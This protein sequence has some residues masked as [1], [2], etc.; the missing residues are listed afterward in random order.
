MPRR[1]CFVFVVQILLILTFFCF[2]SLHG[3]DGDNNFRLIFTGSSTDSLNSN[4]RDV[5]AGSD[6]D[7]D[8]KFEVIVTDYDNGGQVHVFEC[9][10]N[11]TYEWVWSSPGTPSTGTFPTREV[12]TG[13]LDNDGLGEILMSVSRD[14]TPDSSYGIYVYE[15]DGI[16][17][18]GYIPIAVIPVDYQ[19]ASGFTEDFY[20]GDI[21]DDNSTELVF[22][23]AGN[24][25]DDKVYIIS[26]AGTFENEW[27]QN[28]EAVFSRSNGDF[29]TG[30]YDV[31][32]ADLDG[33]GFK[34]LIVGTIE[35]FG[36]LFIAEVTAPDTYVPQIYLHSSTIHNVYYL[37]GMA[38]ADFDNDGADELFLCMYP[39][40]KLAVL[41]S[42]ND[43]S[44][45]SRSG[46]VRILRDNVAELGVAIGDQDHGTGS[47]GLDIYVTYYGSDTEAGYI[48]DLEFTGTD[49]LLASSYTE[50]IIFEENSNVRPGGLFQIDVPTVDLDGDGKKEL[51]LSYTGET[52]NGTYLRIFEFSDPDVNC[53]RGDVNMDGN[54][55][56]GD[57]LCAFQIYLNGG[58]SPAG[59]CNTDC[60]LEA[61]DCNCTPN[62]VTPGDALY[63]FM[64]YLNNE[65]PPLDCDPILGLAKANSKYLVKL[66]QNLAK[67]T[68]E[69]VVSLTAEDPVGLKAFGL[70]IGFPDDMLEFVEMQATELTSDWECFAARE[71]LSGVVRIGGFNSEPIDSKENHII[72]RLVFRIC[73]R[74]TPLA[75]MWTFNATDNF[76]AN[77]YD[78]ITLELSAKNSRLT[79][80][81]EDYQISQNY[82]NPFN[83]ET[84]I[85][86]LLKEP[87]QVS[88]E[89]YDINGHLVRSLIQQ[90]WTTGTHRV[91]WNGKNGNGKNAGSGVYFCR[92]KAW[93]SKGEFN[94]TIKMMLL[95]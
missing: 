12:K 10:G 67:S 33:D 68:N 27:T 72:A 8:G 84:A 5:A 46:N 52:A 56:P 91:V 25:T 4:A 19:L 13:D 65:T 23:N 35:D 45:I 24:S 71:I 77:A 63:I 49:V 9:I 80:L 1:N 11:N 7:Q 54:I 64:G 26:V 82:P 34:E 40:N 18:N 61:A 32:V 21:D 86:F 47:D 87:A 75:K 94:R 89:I 30:P 42:G 74:Q 41:K 22:L 39:V 15:W 17:D 58:E 73:D 37:E 78:E 62:G 92:F 81:A 95:K 36:G 53:Q 14:D 51:L 31:V 3:A 16:N 50:Y 76:A 88:V 59:E 69:I 43:V 85:E 29:D 66:I 57:A 83:Q 79:W 6:L 2:H 48:Q 55:S 90:I 70:D 60:A 93:S 28:T 44:K 20:V 38:A